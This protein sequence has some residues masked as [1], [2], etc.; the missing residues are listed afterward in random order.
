[1]SA[2]GKA[3]A[4]WT[5]HIADYLEALNPSSPPKVKAIL[6]SPLFFDV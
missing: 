4:I 5:D 3:A 2:G 6:D 1:M